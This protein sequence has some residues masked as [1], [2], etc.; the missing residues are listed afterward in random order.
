[1]K[2]GFIGTGVMGQSIVKHFLAAGHEVAVYNRTKSKT[3]ELVAKGAVWQDT[4]A[5]A[6][7]SSE[8]VFSMVGY[9]SDVE[10]IYYGDNGVFSVTVRDKVLVDLTTS[11]PSLAEKIYQTAKEAGAE[12]LDA[13]VSGGD[14]GAQNATLTIMVGGDQATFDKVVPLFD[15]MGKSYSLHGSAGLGQHTKM[16]NQIMIAGTM[17]GM[18]E[19]LV[20]ADKVGLD[21]NS[22]IETLGGGA[23]SNWS[24]ANYGPRILKQDYSPGF[25]VK[26]F[27]KDLKIALD[28]AKKMNLDLPATELA[29]ELYEKLAA[30]GFEN[31]GTQSLI[32][33]W[34]KD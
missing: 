28:E 24:L 17:T 12:S 34:W 31:L 9:P 18:T 33:L 29:T 2:I 20:Y 1:M 22:V 16:A 19:M 14:L 25:F 32:K 6:T 11:S 3:D 23:A 8:V 21:L 4:P 30:D 5:K 13:P 26:H 7:E 10:E 15:I 27:I